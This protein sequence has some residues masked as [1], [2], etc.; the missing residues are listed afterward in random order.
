MSISPLSIMDDSPIRFPGLF[1]DWEFTASSVA[2]HI[3]GN[4]GCIGDALIV[5]RHAGSNPVSYTHLSNGSAVPRPPMTIGL[6]N[7]TDNARRMPY[8]RKTS[9]IAL[10]FGRFS[11]RI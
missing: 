4:G 7:R 9:A 10:I 3:A 2:L 11:V 6:S 1:G 5:N 8:F